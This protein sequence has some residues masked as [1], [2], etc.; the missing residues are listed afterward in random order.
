MR[1]PIPAIVIPVVVALLYWFVPGV[2]EA[3][4]TPLRIAGAGL[5]VAAYALVCVARLQL[6]ASFAV[7]AVARRLV[8]T[9]L[10]SRIRHPIYVF[11]DLLFLG[12][13]LALGLPWLLILLPIVAAIQVLKA[14][15]EERV[16]QDAFGQKYI[17]Y[18]KR[19]WF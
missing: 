8:T 3:P 2:R 19:T 7:R 17:D 11:V 5:A 14:R 4:W 10:Y 6:G 16:L 13:M 1:A 12:A 9:G 15:R 18:R